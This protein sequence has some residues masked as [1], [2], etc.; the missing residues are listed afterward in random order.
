MATLPGGYT[1][2]NVTPVGYTELG[3]RPAFKM[4]VREVRGR[5]YLYTGHFWHSGWSIVDVTDPA[6]P[7]VVRF[8]EGRKT[9]ERCKSTFPG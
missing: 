2:E 9:L 7:E 3:D 8:I 4:T 5:W 6:E 1:A